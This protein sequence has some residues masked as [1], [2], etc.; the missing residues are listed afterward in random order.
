MRAVTTDYVPTTVPDLSHLTDTGRWRELGIT[1]W[2]LVT[3][4]TATND[5]LRYTAE[6]WHGLAGARYTHHTADP[7]EALAWLANERMTAIH[8]SSDPARTART[9]GWDTEREW[10]ARHDTTWFMLTHVGKPA[11]GG[12]LVSDGRSVDVFAQPMTPATC[13]RHE[14]PA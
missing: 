1:H 11:G 3:D 2:H 8:R 6:R 9:A 12:I 7:H 5:K 4:D 10:T 13:H 14:G